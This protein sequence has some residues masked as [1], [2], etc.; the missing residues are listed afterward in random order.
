VV[1]TQLDARVVRGRAAAF[2]LLPEFDLLARRE[3]L[4]VTARAPW[5][6]ALLV[7]DPLARPWAVTA[8]GAD[9]CLRAAVVLLDEGTGRAVLA[10]GGQGYRGGIPAAD[11]A[12]LALLGRRLAEEAD[13]HGVT[14]L[15]PGL[16]DDDAIRGL[17]AA[18]GAD[19]EPEPPIPAL[20]L[21]SG[22]AAHRDLATYL[23][24]GTART[25]RKARN[26]LATDGRHAAV[27]I[28]RRPG[29]VAACLPFMEQAYRGR[30]REHGLACPLD[31][32]LGLARWRERI[33]HLLDDR[34]LELATITVDGTLAAYVLG[35]RDG[36]GYG[37]LEGNFDSTWSRY[38]PG[39]VLEAEVLR[40][41]LV[42]PCVANVDW[43]TAVAPDSLLAANT[44]Q[45][46]VTLRRVPSRLTP[47]PR[48]PGRSG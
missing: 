13:L 18:L 21:P 32:P 47:H 46:V 1:A 3:R 43:M 33:R 12:A 14:L 40:R 29:A 26:R 6:R 22:D 36:A 35:V 20:T 45:A 28:T 19:V 8:R 25:L 23:T 42:D 41:A 2:A 39:R 4:P 44:A 10:G 48:R 31:T 17:A 27:E 37:I 24:H 9:G 34:R 16:P 15:L 30:D 5:I 11:G 7:A 38:S